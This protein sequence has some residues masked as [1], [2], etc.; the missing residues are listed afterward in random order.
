MTS[1]VGVWT[2]DDKEYFRKNRKPKGRKTQTQD[3]E[4]DTKDEEIQAVE[5]QTDEQTQVDDAVQSS[6]GVLNK[7]FN[8][9]DED[10][11]VDED[12]KDD[13]SGDYDDDEWD[14]SDSGGD[15]FL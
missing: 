7:A 10:I 11:G 9:T 14:D 1:E 15:T 2:G 6:S 8:M 12:V 4:H 3:D 5:K 13:A